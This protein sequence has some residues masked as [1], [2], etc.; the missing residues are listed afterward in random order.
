M[1]NRLK[2]VAFD[3]DPASL[4]TLGQ[5]FPEWEIQTVAGATAGS[6]DRDWNPAVVDLLLVGARDHMADTLT[7]CRSLRSQAGRA[8][9]PLL[10]LVTSGQES[11]ANATLQA[12]ASGYMVLPVLV[13]TLL[14]KLA[15]ALAGTHR[16]DPWQ[17]DGGEA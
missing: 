10:V 12:G 13:K 1:Q 16:A 17:D 2:A 7:L 5:A 9:T 3:V 6:L 8:Q 15:A 4:L 11:L 14:S